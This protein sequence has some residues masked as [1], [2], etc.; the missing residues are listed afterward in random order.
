MTAS[1]QRG[2]PKL[3]Q[4]VRLSVEGASTQLRATTT[5]HEIGDDGAIIL[6][7]PPHVESSK[8]VPGDRAALEYFR[9]DAAYQLTSEIDAIEPADAFAL[10]HLRRPSRIKK[11]QKRRFPRLRVQLPMHWMRIE[12]GA[13][14]EQDAALR[15]RHLDVWAKQVHK[16][17][18]SGRSEAISGSGMR[19]A[20]GEHLREGEAIYVELE[21]GELRLR[22]A[23]LVTWAGRSEAG[24]DLAFAAGLEF[25]SI[26]DS[27]RDDIL[28][29]VDRP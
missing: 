28:A 18:E 11:V 9:E 15:Q 7:L 25:V 4:G 8:L 17:G 6:R 5:V 19:L 20:L 10:L 21:L 26:T 1:S 24:T 2:Y 23:G 16:Q 3:K 14:F 29:L 22:Q 13:Q 27:E 12:L